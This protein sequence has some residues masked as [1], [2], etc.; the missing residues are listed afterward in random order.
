M[1]SDLLADVVR[2]RKRR[3]WIVRWSLPGFFAL[4]GFALMA[5]FQSADTNVSDA[6]M[7]LTFPIA[8]IGVA[9]WAFGPFCTLIALWLLFRDP[10]RRQRPRAERIALTLLVLGSPVAWMGSNVINDAYHLLR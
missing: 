5:A 8:L 7:I 9:S 6:W 1:T 4:G 3:R 2:R 10:W